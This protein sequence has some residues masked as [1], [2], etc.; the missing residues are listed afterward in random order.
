MK[1]G[2]RNHAYLGENMERAVG[3]DCN[4]PYFKNPN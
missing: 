4:I 2:T 3:R 1:Y